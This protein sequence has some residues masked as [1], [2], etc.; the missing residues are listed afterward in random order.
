MP[1]SVKILLSSV[2]LVMLPFVVYALRPGQTRP[3]GAEW[4]RL[5]ARDPLRRVLY[6]DNGLPRLHSWI[7]AVAWFALWIAILW[8]LPSYP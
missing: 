2:A 1:V 6:R 7:I 8:L 3:A 5:G 4:W